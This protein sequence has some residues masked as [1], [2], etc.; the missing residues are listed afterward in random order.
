MKRQKYSLQDGDLS[1]LHFGDMSEPVRLVMLH[2]NGF[3]GQSYRAALEPL[4]VHAIALD[5][6]GHGHSR[7]LPQPDDIA[8]FHIFRDDLI[9]F[10]ELHLPKLTD[11]PVVLAGHSLGAVVSIL[12]APFVKNHLSGFVGLDPVAIP[13]LF[14]FISSLPG[15]RAYMKKRLPIAR[16]AGRRKS[17][18]ESPEA[19]FSRWQGRGAF[20]SMADEVLRDYISS[21]L[22]EREDGKW[23]LACA[24]KWEQTIFAAQGHNMFKAARALPDNSKILFAGGRQPVS[25][26]G[27]RAAVQRA[28]PNIDVQFDPALDHLFPL[29]QPHSTRQIFDE[30]LR[31]AKP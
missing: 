16:H 22:F 6:R 3:N 2:G 30:V 5:L 13:G 24:P 19:A 27:T 18:F 23:E 29:I 28:Q 26:Q 9:A 31:G 14:R 7:E 11:G 15:G 20:K 4:G 10:F 1:A 25:S 8:S 17:E 12:A 21:G